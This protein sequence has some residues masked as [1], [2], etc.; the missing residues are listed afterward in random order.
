VNRYKLM[1][2]H[3][4]ASWSTADVY[5]GLVR[6]LLAQGHE[7]VSYPL[8]VR[9]MRASKW[10]NVAWEDSK[11]AGR[12]LPEPTPADICFE[13]NADAVNRAAYAGV[14]GVL[15]IS[16]MYTPA[17]TLRALKWAHCPIG[18]VLTESPY[19]D[20]EQA[21][22]AVEAD[23]VWTNER[24][25]VEPLRAANPETYYLPA[26]YDPSIHTSEPQPGDEDV[27]AHDV[28][29]VGTGFAERVALLEAVDW[30]GID[31]ALYGNWQ[32]LADG[33]PLLPFVHGGVTDNAVAAALYRRAK[34]GLNL[35]RTSTATEDGGHVT[36]AE[37]L[38]PR[39][40][41]LAACGCFQIA[42]F[43]AESPE[44]VG[45]AVQDF[46]PITGADNDLEHQIRW[47]LAHPVAREYAVNDAW[48]G[49][50]GHTFAA[51]AEQLMAQFAPHLDR[52]LVA[53]YG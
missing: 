14:D 31:L 32:M 28:V 3:P 8:D 18:L 52:T 51:R 36:T 40:Y 10:L 30:S 15:I 39:A 34:I 42:N 9:L 22:L 20:A 53:A 35:Y 47:Y 5:N 21:R 48:D 29:F 41:E 12:P 50:R 19:N 23:V 33:S 49:V 45:G 16:S 38:N 7:I 24:T 2:L 6:A 13:A 25:S 4:G 11:E 27:P 26:A 44:M 43:R 37:S 46:N 1:V 17:V